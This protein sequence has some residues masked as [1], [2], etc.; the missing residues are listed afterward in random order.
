MCRPNPDRGEAECQC[1]HRHLEMDEEGEIPTRGCVRHEAKV[2]DSC[3]SSYQCE[4]VKAKC[5]TKSQHGS[6]RVCQ[7]LGGE[8]PNKAGAVH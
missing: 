3:T 5:R 1:S 8:Y 2:G 4:A 6:K 7:C